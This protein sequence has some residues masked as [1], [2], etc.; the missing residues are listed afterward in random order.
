MGDGTTRRDFINATMTAAAAAAVM[1][2]V[3]K[4]ADALFDNEFPVRTVE[5][6]NF[7][8]DPKTGML[9]WTDAHRKEPYE[10]TVDG[11]VEKP[12]KY[13]YKD[14]QN[15]EQ[16]SQVSDFH[17]V[18]GWS[19]FDLKWEGFRFGEITR[20]AKPKQNA[21]HVIF[22][23]LGATGGSPQGQ[24]YYIESMPIS[25]LLDP[26]NQCMMALKLE[27]VPLPLDHGSPLRL[28]SPFNLGYKN[29]KYV[30]RIEFSNKERPGW[31]TLANP[32]YPIKAPVPERRLR[33]K[34]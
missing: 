32:I 16:G 18:E 21:T 27:G 25:E 5:I 6:D 9:Q 7:A 8:F 17:C 29:I 34:K 1:A 28:I 4:S 24:T 31:W 15:F 23:A 33:R 30:R 22:H 14:L 10:L 2:M 19:V 12:A 20:R 3:P 26:S 11:L 13:N